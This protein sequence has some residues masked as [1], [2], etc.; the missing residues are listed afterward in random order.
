MY[1]RSARTLGVTAVHRML[2]PNQFEV[3]EAWIAFRL[4][5]VPI[6][7]EQDGD[8]ICIALM[9]AA[10]CFILGMELIPAGAADLSRVEALRLLESAQRHKQRY[11]RTLF[12]PRE[13]AGD[14]L[15]QE[16]EQ[17]NIDVIRVP[18]REVLIFIEE[19][20]QGFAE[21]F[22]ETSGDA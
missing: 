5:S 4:N 3:S 9:D 18:E 22:E 15:T 6:K 11:P 12:I 8:L 1:G 16:A 17:Q 19:A 13:D 10:S 2:H 14:S 20:R 7:T 21:R